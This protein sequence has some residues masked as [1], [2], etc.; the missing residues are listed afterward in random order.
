M[1]REH[2]HFPY[3]LD[4]LIRPFDLQVTGIYRAQPVR[5]N[6]NKRTLRLR[7]RTALCACWTRSLISLGASAIQFC[8]IHGR[9]S[10]LET[11][12]TLASTHAL[13]HPLTRTT[14]SP[15][16]QVPVS[17]LCGCFTFPQIRTGRL[18]RHEPTHLLF[19]PSARLVNGSATRASQGK[20]VLENSSAQT[21]SEYFT[22]FEVCSAI[23]GRTYLLLPG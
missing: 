23:G 5:V 18:T 22:E 3:H 9:A 12:Q 19:S 1:A 16:W 14:H 4:Q 8:C 20:I 21:D 2:V 17:A 15:C 10:V 13:T 11:R 6:H 7:A